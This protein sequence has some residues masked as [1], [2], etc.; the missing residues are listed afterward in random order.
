M[1]IFEGQE[2][3]SDVARIIKKFDIYICDLGDS[4][5]ESLLNKS[6]PCVIVSNENNNCP[7][8]ASYLIAPIRTE[9]N[10]EFT[11]ET[12]EDVVNERRKVGRIYVPIEIAPDDFRF[13]DVTQARPIRSNKVNSYCNSIINEDL[14]KRINIALVEKYL[15]ANEINEIMDTIDSEDQIY[16]NEIENYEVEGVEEI[17]QYEEDK[18]E[19]NVPETFFVLYEQYKQNI[20]TLKEASDQLQV[21]NDTFINLVTDYESTGAHKENLDMVIKQPKKGRGTKFPTGFS[22][23]YKSY[24]NKKM[25]VKQISEKSGLSASQIRYYIKRY[26]TLKADMYQ[27]K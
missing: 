18:K 9:H 11:R 16:P 7:K 26:E 6:R 23:Y 13:I 19:T 25:T 14:K 3:Y 2:Y 5:D 27:V 10:I 17:E 4:T 12:V 22:L 20:I 8:S 24:K 1:C 15:S 21:S